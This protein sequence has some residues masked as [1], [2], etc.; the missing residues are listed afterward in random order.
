[1]WGSIPAKGLKFSSFILYTHTER[2]W[3]TFLLILILF[4]FLYGLEVGNRS[5]RPGCCPYPLD[6]DGTEHR[7]YSWSYE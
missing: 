5:E 6:A 4:L 1:M 3:Y 2:I 7:Q